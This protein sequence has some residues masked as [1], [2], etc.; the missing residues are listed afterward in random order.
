MRRVP[1]G[2][3]P[4]LS[5]GRGTR[6]YRAP[7][8]STSEHILPTA[9]RHPQRRPAPS[10]AGTPCTV[11]TAPT[12]GVLGV[13]APPSQPPPGPAPAAHQHPHT[14]LPS[15]PRRTPPRAAPYQKEV[16]APLI[17]QPAPPGRSHGAG[18]LRG[19]TRGGGGG[20]TAGR[21]LLF[22]WA[23]PVLPSPHPSPPALS[24][25][26]RGV[27]LRP[28]RA[29]FKPPPSGSSH[30]P[31]APATFGT[32]T[33]PPGAAAL[34]AG[35][36]RDPQPSRPEQSGGFGRGHPRRGF[37]SPAPLSR[38]DV[39]GSSHPPHLEKRFSP[40]EKPVRGV[41][42]APA[43]PLPTALKCDTKSRRERGS[44]RACKC[45]AIRGETKRLSKKLLLACT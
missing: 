5:P 14:H 43:S 9:H 4:A 2:R 40:W 25:G 30:P 24:S 3:G 42:P 19:S 6:V 35:L 36:P 29:E 16:F 32:P 7:A 45:S 27:A 18:R 39:A 37:G 1:A 26:R 10:T 22:S 17:G 34:P 11:R 38:S 41:P 33:R 21:A 13:C 20:E 31:R 8:P 23:A 44:S 12:T 15:L 28:R